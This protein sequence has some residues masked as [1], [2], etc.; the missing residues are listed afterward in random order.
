MR[1][2]KIG[3]SID[4]GCWL[5]EPSIEAAIRDTAELLGRSGAI[6]E[7]V[8]P[9][10]RAEDELVWGKLWAVFMAAYYGHLLDQFGHLMTPGVVRL[11]ERGNSMGAVEYKRLEIARTDMWRRIAPVFADHDVLLCPTMSTA[12]LPAALADQSPPSAT[13]DG[14]YRS[15]D[16]TGVFNLISPCP[17][18][19]VPC[20]LD[21]NGLPIGAQIVGRR[22]QDDVVLSVGAALESAVQPV[23][24]PPEREQT[25]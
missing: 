9:S 23:G 25:G 7:E 18:L 15:S 4:L 2:L 11:I 10:L 20:G 24:R 21:P 1:G 16:M 17:A 22:W 14:R 13:T 5:V 12:P 8:N 6:V 3:L 19:S